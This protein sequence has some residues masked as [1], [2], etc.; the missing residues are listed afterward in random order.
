M[1]GTVGYGQETG[2]K[3][4]IPTFFPTIPDLPD[5][6]KVENGPETSWDG[7]ETS[8]P[9][10][11]TSFRTTADQVYDQQAICISE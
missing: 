7:W 3:T 5:Q 6:V 11:S 10:I 9:T 2:R 8:F 4:S 1:K